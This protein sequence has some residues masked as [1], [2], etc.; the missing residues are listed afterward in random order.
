[1]FRGYDLI[2]LVIVAPLL[3]VTLLPALR[4][5]V[6]AQLLWTG[7]LAYAVYHSAP[8]VFGTKFND[9][10]LV[11]VAVFSLSVF[12][13]GLAIAKPGR[14]RDSPPVQRPDARTVDRC[15]P[16]ASGGHAG[17]VLD[18]SFDPVRDH[19]RNPGGKLELIVPTATTH[20]GWVLDL[21]MLVPA[22]ALAGILLW[23]RAAWG[24][25]LAAVVLVGGSVQQIDYVTALVFQANEHIPG[26][27]GFDPFEPVIVTL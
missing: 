16:P 26:A 11:H 7:G 12:A 2:A 8:Y 24:Y 25:V 1:M 5:S 9:I 19:G 10:F 15:D 18:R 4:R 21:S 3:A 14:P 27:S 6:R 13:F 20:L 17:G 22:Y 23:R